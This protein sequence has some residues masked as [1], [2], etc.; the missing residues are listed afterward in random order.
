MF[1]FF[2]IF[3]F[4]KR[5]EFYDYEIWKGLE[6]IWGFIIYFF[7]FLGRSSYVFDV[8]LICLEISFNF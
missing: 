1:L 7:S 4:F 3:W 8:I 5:K 6:R 2:K